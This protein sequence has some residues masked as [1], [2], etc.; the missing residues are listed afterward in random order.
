MITRLTVIVGVF[1][2]LHLLSAFWNPLP[3]W[4]VDTLRFLPDA[5]LAAFFALTAFLLIPR[6]RL[7]L[8]RLSA[9]LPVAVGFL[10]RRGS[11]LLLLVVAS[12]AFFGASLCD[13]SPRRRLPAAEGAGYLDPH[14]EQQAPV[15]MAGRK[16]PR[17]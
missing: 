1:L 8:V 11:M 12:V 14:R 17:A 15:L 4:G 6:T 10:E 9:K 3:L 16:A 13:P 5:V 2:G 7:Y